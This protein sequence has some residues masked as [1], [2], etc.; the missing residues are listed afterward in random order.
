MT[1]GARPWATFYVDDDPARHE[2]PETLELTPGRHRV[3]FVNEQA[4]VDRTIT[5]DVPADRDSKHVEVLVPD[6]APP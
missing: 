2:T 3:R 1:I 5:L 4:H 6:D